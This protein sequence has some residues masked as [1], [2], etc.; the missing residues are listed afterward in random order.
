MA[1][2]TTNSS[3]PSTSWDTSK[4]AFILHVSAKS[5]P[6]D[7][8]AFVPN[9]RSQ[10]HA[11]FTGGAISST[12]AADADGW[13]DV[14]VSSANPTI[15]PEGPSTYLPTAASLPQPDK[16]LLRPPYHLLVLSRGMSEIEIQGSHSPS[17]DLLGAY[18]KKWCR[19]NV[20][21]SDKVRASAALGS[22]QGQ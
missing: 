3:I 15:E 19:T 14:V 4:G 20:R 13:A 5:P 10:A 1:S 21:R 7:P 9:F 8:L 6:A 11:A 16:L 2:K 22:V 17:L 18:L 12:E